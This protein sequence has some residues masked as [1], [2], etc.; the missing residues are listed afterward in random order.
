MSPIQRSN[1]RRY[2]LAV[3]AALIVMG[4]ASCSSHKAS[5]SATTTAQS[6][7]SCTVASRPVPLAIAVGDRSNVP[8]PAYPSELASLLEATANAGKQIAVVRVDGQPKVFL[9]PPFRTTA[10][11]PSARGRAVDNYLSSIINPY[12][13]LSGNLVAKVPQADL[14]T[15]L[16]LAASATSPNGNIVL[17]D[18]GLQTVAPLDY[19]QPGLLMSPPGDV[20]SFLRHEHLLPDLRGRHVLLV[21]FGYTAA[22]QP[23]LNEAQRDNLIGQWQAIIKAGGGCSQVDTLANT[24]AERPGL[25]AVSVVIPP[26]T[27]PFSNCGTFV[28]SDAGSVGFIVG[29]SKFRDPPAAKATLRTLAAKLKQGTEHITL[30]GSTSSEGGDAINNPLSLHRAQAVKQ[31]LFSLGIA[32]DRITTIGEGSHWAGRKPDIG[33]GGVLLPGP[34][35]EDREVI[36]QLPKCK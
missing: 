10:Q 34:A 12:L 28:L 2:G 7:G 5:S 18:S 3:T 25:P 4:L 35:E 13:E 8:V 29:T 30:I 23:S 31:V 32:A 15:A 6:A 19:P 22:P 14:L 27:P 26:K 24:S 36:V 21:G 1:P 17:I 20:V 33:P 11:N 16:T 9:P